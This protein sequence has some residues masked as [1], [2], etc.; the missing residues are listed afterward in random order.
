MLEATSIQWGAPTTRVSDQ[1]AEGQQDTG[2]QV[3]LVPGQTA[4]FE[5]G[6]RPLT[7]LMIS[8][9]PLAAEMQSAHKQ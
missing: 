1:P 2:G 5:V 4:G 8:P 3:G 9:L 6:Y 7:D